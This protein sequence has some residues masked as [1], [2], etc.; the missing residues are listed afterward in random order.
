MSARQTAVQARAVGRPAIGHPVL[1]HGR[2]SVRVV[3]RTVAVCAGL[4]ALLL[5]VCLL[6]LAVGEVHLT[7]REVYGAL[8]GEPGAADF[9][10]NTLRLPRLLLALL[11]GAALAVSGA[12]LQGLTGN[13]LGSP[14]VIGLTNGAATGAL[15]VIVVRHGSLTETALG[16]LAGGLA[17][18]LLVQLLA[19]G[20]GLP[21]FRLVV[22]GIG[23]SAILLSVNSYLITRA[24]LE[25]ALAAQSWLI[26]SLNSRTWPQVTALAIGVAILLPPTLWYGRRLGMLA[27]GEDT[28]RALGM[29]TGPTRAVLLLLGVAL[30]AV[31][32]AVTGPI[33]FVA[34]AAPQLARRLVGGRGG[35]GGGLVPAAL[36]GALLLAASDFAVQRVFAPAPMPVGI[37]TGTL[38]GLYLCLLL[39]GE[40]RKSGT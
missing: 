1:R 9:V 25:D 37:A 27:L 19:S 28:A 5:G 26:G 3:P 40:T 2:W 31:G 29:R 11:V 10:V 14:D 22:I 21:G 39:I 4:A 35:T 34:L 6:S 18:A 20:R 8:T 16:A 17:T 32:T 15:L 33:W 12:V 24:S 13:P 36:S 30:A 23:T 38:G 7:P